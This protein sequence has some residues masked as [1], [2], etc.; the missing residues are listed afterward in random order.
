LAEIRQ[1]GKRRARKRRGRVA[2]QP[3]G[4]VRDSID[5]ELVLRRRLA[6][7]LQPGKDFHGNP[8]VCR[9]RNLN[10]PGR[11]H[12]GVHH[13]PRRHEVRELE[14]L[15]GERGR[16]ER[17]PCAQDGCRACQRMRCE[18]GHV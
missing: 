5:G 1:F 17:K 13:V 12:V 8:V 14:F 18:H 7:E 16:G 3:E 9:A 10:G 4:N 11:H 2:L 6:A 15:G